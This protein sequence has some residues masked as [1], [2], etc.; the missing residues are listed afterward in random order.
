MPWIL[1]CRSDWPQTRRD[2]PAS[3]GIKGVHTLSGTVIFSVMIRQVCGLQPF[4]FLTNVSTLKLQQATSHG[5]GWP[6]LNKSWCQ[7]LF[8][9]LISHWGVGVYIFFFFE[10][11]LLKF[12]APFFHP[13]DR[14][15][16]R[17]C[18]RPGTCSAE[19]TGLELI[20]KQ[21]GPPEGWG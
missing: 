11:W 16:L 3:A 21:R 12:S 6:F 9:E 18:G 8:H 7:V 17:S 15:S 20:K 19:Q 14:V 1:L 5:F 13:W 4:H 2:P 10:K